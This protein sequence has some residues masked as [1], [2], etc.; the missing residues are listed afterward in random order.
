L[1]T[2]LPYNRDLANRAADRRTVPPFLLRLG[3]QTNWW[4]SITHP[5]LLWFA[6]ANIAAGQPAQQVMINGRPMMIMP[7][8]PPQPVASPAATPPATTEA[9][10]TDAAA[11]PEGDKPKEEPKPEETVKRPAKPPRTPDPRELEA[12]PDKNGRVT[13]GFTGQPWPDV[14]QWLANVS[15]QSL[16][17]QELPN[18]YL[19][20][21]TQ[22]SYTIPEARDLVNRHLQARGYV[23]IL[24]GEVLSVHKLDKLDPSLVPRVEEEQLYDLPPHDLV[25]VTFAIPEGLEPAKAVEDLKQT[26]SP[27]AKLL[28]LAAT[29]RLL[30]IDTVAN[31]RMVS[32]L[33]SDETLAKHKADQPREFVLKYA[34]AEQVIDKLYVILGLDP[35]SRPSDMELQLQQQKMQMMMQ[36]QQTGVD[37]S[38]L[39]QKAGPPVF[40]VYNRQRNSVLVNAPDEQLAIVERA[41]KMLDVP[42]GDDPMA[43]DIESRRLE[44]YVL[45]AMDPERLVK[46]L[47]EIGD[48]SP[49]SE[50]RADSDSKTLF[51]RGTERDHEQIAAL[52]KQ[53]DGSD[54]IVEVFWLRRLPADA[55]AGSIAALMSPPKKKEES[56]N[57]P[58]YYGWDDNNQ[59][60]DEPD[61]TE[62]RV[63][64]DVLNNRLIT[65]GTQQQLTEVREL[66]VKLGEPLDEQTSDRPVRVL[67]SLGPEATAKLLEQVKAAWPTMG[68]GSELKIEESPESVTP[69]TQD[70]EPSAR[71]KRRPV[72]H[73]AVQTEPVV[74]P[75]NAQPSKAKPPVSISVAADGRLVLTSDDPALLNRLEGLVISLTP[76]DPAFKVYRPKHIPGLYIYWN[77]QD[78]YEEELKKEENSQILDWFG[79][80]RETGPKEG[81]ALKLSKRR[82]LTLI[83]DAATNS[84]MV[85]NATVSQFEEIDRLVAEWDRPLPPESIKARR[86]ATVKIEYSSAQKIATALKEVYRDLLSSRDKEFETGDDSKKGSTLR[87]ASTTKIRYGS[88]DA[89]PA[90]VR[91]T[92]PIKATFEGAL[93]IGVDEVA[94]ILIVSAQEELFDSVL[95][96]IRVLDAEAKPT[97]A[98]KVHRLNVSAA[99][100]RQALSQT[101]GQQWLGGKPVQ[102]QQPPQN[103]EQNQL[104]NGDQGRRGRRSD[105]RRGGN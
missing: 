29:R 1:A 3:V 56:N 77:L 42:T 14:L 34:R 36:M 54:T 20:L 85:K 40:F 23:L 61:P 96:T 13:F 64:A 6:L 69:S 26:L 84:I 9:P 7:G 80:V 41:I 59:E 22:H 8:Q 92:D 45:K 43:T 16:D 73:L 24:S 55:V 37:V 63:D 47:Q 65:R 94:N 25:K 30:A 51:A 19:N 83:Y 91:T 18:D 38:K 44:R 35:A 57:R 33:L 90:L 5:L 98:V 58:W 89:D 66:L 70:S 39:L 97:T 27:T 93:S 88:A 15:N 71:V 52:I 75:S 46:T 10:K 101:V 82:R 74:A 99:S 17:W 62:L 31:L 50:L 48:L 60:E 72:A 11:K 100:V 28:P 87:V 12:K 49:R 32:A 53:L 76:D 67:D 86:T 21:T 104:Q 2:R 68:D 78:Y 105:G 95:D 4:K 102:V 103:P 81:D 79:R